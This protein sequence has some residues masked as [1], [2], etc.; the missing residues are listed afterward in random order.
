MSVCV[1]VTCCHVEQCFST[2]GPRP[3]TVPW[4]QLIWPREFLLEFVILI[5]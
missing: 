5:F 4:H 2:A 3:G 1:S